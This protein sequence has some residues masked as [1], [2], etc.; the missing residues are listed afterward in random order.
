MALLL[1]PLWKGQMTRKAR[2]QYKYVWINIVLLPE[3]A[4]ACI[5]NWHNTTFLCITGH[6][7]PYQNELVVSV[8]LRI[9]IKKWLW[10][11]QEILHLNESK[12]Y[13]RNS[14]NNELWLRI[15]LQRCLSNF[16]WIV[17]YYFHCLKAKRGFGQGIPNWLN[18]SN[19][20]QQGPSTL[21]A[22]Y[23]AYASNRNELVDNQ[24]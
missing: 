11:Q 4:I 15:V 7:F 10:K 9:Y 23:C 20:V 12:S 13:S 24:N 5:L 3:L 6:E 18:L 21:I 19:M 22:N 2:N 1:S 17:I 16:L 8:L 14:C